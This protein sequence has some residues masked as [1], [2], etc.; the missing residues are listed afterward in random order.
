MAG[1]YNSA[2]R[3]NVGQRSRTPAQE[4][5]ALIRYVIEFEDG[6]KRYYTTGQGR[7]QAY[8]QLKEQGREYL[9]KRQ[10]MTG[11]TQGVG[12]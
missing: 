11:S 12:N 1:R 6:T 3:Y 10:Y 4:G 5:E 7:Y 2:G 9:V 8:R